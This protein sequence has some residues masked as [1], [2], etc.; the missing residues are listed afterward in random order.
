MQCTRKD[1]EIIVAQMQGELR[2]RDWR[3]D[4]AFAP[5][6]QRAPVALE[7]IVDAKVASIAVDPSASRGAIESKIREAMIR[8]HTA[9]LEVRTGDEQ[10]AQTL[11]SAIGSAFGA[12]VHVRAY[13]RTA[14]NKSPAKLATT[15]TRTMKNDEDN[16]KEREAHRD[17][18]F[19]AEVMAK[20]RDQLTL[21]S[22]NPGALAY[23]EMW[24]KKLGLPKDAS[25]EEIAVAAAERELK[26]ERGRLDVVKM[27]GL[28]TRQEEICRELGLSP[29]RFLESKSIFNRGRK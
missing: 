2:L 16:R 9:P 13:A 27:N 26:K 10:T 25:L 8:L 12:P 24:R 29:E 15:G 7:R 3:I 11:A 22:G 20:I 5:S 1:L 23:A 28:T 18:Q 17:G 4:I 14:G 6:P 21:H 19:I